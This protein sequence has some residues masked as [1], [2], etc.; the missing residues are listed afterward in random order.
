[1]KSF[2]QRCSI[3]RPLSYAGFAAGA[4]AAALLAVPLAAAEVLTARAFVNSQSEQAVP[5]TTCFQY[6]TPDLR[7][8][9]SAVAPSPG[10]GGRAPQMDPK[11]S[12]SRRPGG[13]H[14]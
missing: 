3:R 14:Q 7:Q 12:N 2:T 5:L 6:R 4:V 13:L 9:V 11:S 10:G 1:M 8:S